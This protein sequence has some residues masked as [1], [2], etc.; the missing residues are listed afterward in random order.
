MSADFMSTSSIG[1]RQKLSAGGLVVFGLVCV[2]V[3]L[4]EV[5]SGNDALGISHWIVP[6]GINLFNN[7][8]GDLSGYPGSCF[9]KGGGTSLVHGMLYGLF[10]GFGFFAVNMLIVLWIALRHGVLLLLLFPFY[11]FS[12]ALPSKDLL[13][14]LL[15]LEWSR[16]LERSAWVSVVLTL[17]GLYLVRDGNMFS[18]LACTGAILLWRIGV[19]WRGLALASLAFCGIMFVYGSPLLMHIPIYASYLGVYHSHSWIDASSVTDYL[20]RLVGNSSN[21]AMRTVFVDSHG[22]LSLLGP[23]GLVSGLSMLAAFCFS[24]WSFIKR[25]GRNR[26]VFASLMLLVALAVLSVN[27]LV[28]PRY[29]MPYAVAFFMLVHRQYGSEEKKGVWGAAIALTVLGIVG[30]GVLPIPHPPVPIVHE[31]WLY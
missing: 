17:V 19:P 2:I 10:G 9:R 15:V 24:V 6:D 12:L 22:G 3:Y 30:Y 5:L 26:V 21:I 8:M 16:S 27:P 7:L 28:Q 23:V 29:L 31:F 4:A 18:S 20:I 11:L 14:L 25:D 1:T 13:V